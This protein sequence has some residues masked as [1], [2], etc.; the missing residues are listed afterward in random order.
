MPLLLHGSKGHSRM[1][2]SRLQAQLTDNDALCSLSVYA[3]AVAGISLAHKNH[4]SHLLPAPAVYCT[5]HCC[6]SCSTQMF[7]NLTIK[8]SEYH[9]N[10]GR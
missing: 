8:V 9:T 3:F 10:D 5:Q 7:P 2:E 6:V 4:C 1:H